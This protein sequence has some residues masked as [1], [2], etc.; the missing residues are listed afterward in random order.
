MTVA[1]TLSGPTA[2]SNWTPLQ[3][4]RVD[5][6]CGVVSPMTLKN[7]YCKIARPPPPEVQIYCGAAFA[8]RQYL[9]LYQRKLAP[10]GCNPAE[11][12]RPQRGEI[13]VCPE[14][15]PGARATLSERNR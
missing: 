3:P 14:T 12:F 13:G 2:H 4:L 5:A 6:R 10:H 7:R 9:A 8:H 1:A 11:M 15:A